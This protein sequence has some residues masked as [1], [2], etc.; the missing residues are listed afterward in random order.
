MKNKK[1]KV[2][3][4]DTE[5]T[6][7]VV[8][9]WGL[10]EQNAIETLE[11]WYMLSYAYKWE[12]EK[13]V[14]VVA[15]PDF[16]GY[17]KDKKNDKALCESLHKLFNE[18]DL[19]VAHN[20]DEHDQKKSNA[21]FIYHGLTPPA[22]YKSIDTK[23]VAKKYFKFNSNSLNNLGTYLRLGNKIENSGIKLW[24]ACME[25]DM[26]AWRIMK[27]Y[28]K[29]DVVLLEKVY[30]ILTP[31]MQNIPR[32]HKDKKVCPRCQGEHYQSRGK[33]KYITGDYQ[34]LQC[35]D[36]SHWYKGDKI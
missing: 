30:H 26:K 11:E 18:A 25:G 3:F 29:Q 28:N 10:W 23:K 7:T 22:P 4:Y 17:V 20:G 36:C 14:H 6:P 24:R 13:K 16:K 8:T 19:V 32:F 9:T 21:R 35:M 27:K 15:L 12:G 1:Q 5:N 2:L 34:R 31:W 33:W